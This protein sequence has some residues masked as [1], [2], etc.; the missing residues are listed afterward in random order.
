MHTKLLIFAL[1]ALV[2]FTVSK[3]TYEGHQVLRFNL[4]SKAQLNILHELEEKNLVDIWTEH[5]GLS[6]IDVRIPANFRAEVDSR[7]LK[8]YNIESEV[9]VKNLQE[10]LNEEE[11]EFAK[12]VKYDPKNKN[13]EDDFF[14]SFRT[15][16]EMNAWMKNKAET[17]KICKLVNA[18][19]THE[20]RD[21]LGLRITS[22]K[23]ASFKKLKTLHHGGIHA[24]EWISPSTVMYI[25]NELITKYETDA[26]VQHLVDRLEFHM[27]PVLNVDGFKYTHTN[28]RMWRKT[29]RPNANSRCI[30]TDPN[31]NWGFKW[32]SGG[33]S[34]SPCSE[35]Y[36][37]PSAWS[38]KCVVAMRDY[39]IS[40]GKNFKSYIDWHAYG[41]LYMRPWGWTKDAP[42]DEE[43]MKKVGDASAEA[44]TRVRGK[45]YRSGRIAIIIY[46]ASG[47]TADYFYGQHGV[48]S[49]AME[50]G[51]SFTMPASEIIPVGK[52]NWEGF[53][54]FAK[55][56]LES[57]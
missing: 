26:T 22:K 43:F 20:G 42:K 13:T 55:G 14:K 48:T 29:R 4:T 53:K 36:H 34:N 45:R 12:R 11:S 2:C 21:I 47:S 1:F 5:Q 33:T 32:N 31:R 51:T 49:Y 23:F 41:Q 57:K 37:G 18:G 16:E 6:Q 17:S 56:T 44:I 25:M 39:G 7:L 8:K 52:E 30:G 24:R 35:I 38:E 15:I 19:K 28:S 46:V 54:V 3:E 10:I 50:L 27:F 9:I 40:L